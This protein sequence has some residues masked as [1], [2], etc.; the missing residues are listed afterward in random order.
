VSASFE[1]NHSGTLTVADGSLSNTPTTAQAFSLTGDQVSTSAFIESEYRMVYAA[2]QTSVRVKIGGT[3]GD[4]NLSTS[5]SDVMATF[6]GP[7]AA[8]ESYVLRL[9]IRKGPAWAGSN[10]YWD[11]S[12]NGGAGSLTFAPY[13]DRSKEMYQGVFFQWG[14]L[15][16]VD[17]STNPNNSGGKPWNNS[18][19]GNVLYTPSYDAVTPANST[20]TKETGKDLGSWYVSTVGTGARNTDF[21][22]SYS[23]ANYSSKLG[24]ICR[25]LSETDEGTG[26]VKGKYR[27]P[28]LFELVKGDNSGSITSGVDYGNFSSSG[29]IGKW[30]RVGDDTDWVQV[31]TTNPDG[32]YALPNGVAYEGYAT[33]PAGGERATVNH[34]SIPGDIMDIGTFC[35]YWSCSASNYSNYADAFSSS[36]PNTKISTTLDRGYMMSIRCILDE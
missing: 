17:P 4:Q 6:T 31:Y 2:S 3:I 7:L 34:M 14:S 33:F 25:Y 20:W 22:A 21:F 26:V 18:P 23:T 9:R 30:K 24:D 29:V 28:T 13:T 5:F 15:V 16:G 12:L 19:S 8:N 10:V 27:M 11:Q 35:H 1:T 36:K 32:T